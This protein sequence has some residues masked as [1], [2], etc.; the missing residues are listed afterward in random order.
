MDKLLKLKEL[1]DQFAVERDWVKYHT[2]SNLSKSISIE[3][4]ELLECF[5]WDE[6]EFNLEAVKE[7]LADV[8]NY[9]IRLA[10]V[11]DLDIYDI[12]TEK[13]EKNATK[14]PVV[15]CLGKATKYDKL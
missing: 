12:V 8:L 3:A 10:S 15:K 1:I 9:S 13:M 6:K 5:Q 7:E 11:L 4:S 14:Y 2:P